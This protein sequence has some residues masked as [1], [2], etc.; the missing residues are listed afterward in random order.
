MVGDDE[1]K[2]QIMRQFGIRNTLDPEENN[3]ILYGSYFS[4]WM[5]VNVIK[6]NVDLGRVHSGEKKK[7]PHLNPLEFKK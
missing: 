3:N 2:I 5:L 4:L 7:A 1:K 6:E